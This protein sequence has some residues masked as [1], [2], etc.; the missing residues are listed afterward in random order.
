MLFLFDQIFK[1]FFLNQLFRNVLPNFHIFG[2]FSPNAFLLLIF[3]LIFLLSESILSMVLSAFTFTDICFITQHIVCLWKC[4][5]CFKKS[6]VFYVDGVEMS[7]RLTVLF[8]VFVLW[9]IFCLLVLSVTERG[10]L[11]SPNI[12]VIVFLHFVLSSFTLWF[13]SIHI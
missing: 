6:H 1:N 9:L 7:N 5:M 13:W 2:D 8:Q 12:N 3:N 11:K 10:V 4:F